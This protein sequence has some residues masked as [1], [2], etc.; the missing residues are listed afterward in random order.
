MPQVPS[1]GEAVVDFR[2]R[3]RGD[4][5]TYVA[6]NLDARIDST[7]AGGDFA[8]SLLGDSLW[9]HDTN[10]RFSLVDTHLIEQLFPAVHVPRHGTLSGNAKL[11]GPP[12][13]MRVD[14]DVAFDDARYG[15]SRVIAV[16]GVGTT[17]RGVRFRDLDVTLDPVQV[18]MA[19]VFAPSLPIAG[20]LRGSARVNGESDRQMVVRADLTHNDAGVR[21]RIAGNTTMRLG[22]R[23]WLDVDVRLLPLALAEVGKFAPAAGLTGTASGPVRL[24][25]DLGNLRLDSR[26]VLADGG[27]LDA[28]ERSISPASRRAT[29]S[30]RRCA[31]S[32]RRA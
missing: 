2:L 6:R 23:R 18:G 32:T 25:G 4:T 16:G 22:D 29:I 7:R 31:S 1:R 5:A 28:R 20:T 24:T 21:S 8:I 17:G 10:M 30:R 11:D 27:R 14:G 26:L 12:G 3:W 9:F 15:R 13:L 19:R